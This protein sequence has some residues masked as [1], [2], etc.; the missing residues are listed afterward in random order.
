METNKVRQPTP[1]PKYRERKFVIHSILCFIFRSDV[2]EIWLFARLLSIAPY[3][4]LPAYAA[5]LSID[6][7][8][9]ARESRDHD[10]EILFLVLLW[11]AA[12]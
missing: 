10:V 1:K 3:P 11:L 6:H 9:L 4:V 7:N 12:C 2:D 5:I 8:R